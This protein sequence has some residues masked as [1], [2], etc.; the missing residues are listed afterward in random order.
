VIDF[1]HA[2][3]VS[4]YEKMEYVVTVANELRTCDLPFVVKLQQSLS[5]YGTFIVDS[6]AMR[7]NTIVQLTSET[8]P[9]LL[10]KVSSANVHLHPAA[11]ILSEF[12]PSDG[13]MAISFF[14]KPSARPVFI[15]GTWQIFNDERHFDGCFIN[16]TE[17]DRIKH[18]VQDL[19]ER[20][21]IFVNLRGYCGPIGIDVLKN[22]Y[23]GKLFIVDLNARPCAS[24]VVGLLRGHFQKRGLQWACLRE[25]VKVPF[26]R[27]EFVEV[28]KQELM[29]GKVVIVSWHEEK[30][31]GGSWGSFVVGAEDQKDLTLTVQRLQQLKRPAAPEEPQLGNGS[32]ALEEAQLDSPAAPGELQPDNGPV[33]LEEAQLESPATPG[34]LQP[35]NGPVALEEAQLDSPAALEEPKP[36]NGP[37]ALV[38]A[39]LDS[40]ATPGEA[41]LDNGP[42]T[43]KEAQ[44]DSLATPGKPQPYDGMVALKEAQLDSPATPGEPQP[45]NGTV[46]LEEAQLHNDTAALEEA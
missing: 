33:V 38:E 36:Y 26:T 11:V 9:T 37:V 4:E 27:K 46:A 21:A 16:Y 29:D 39:Q 32:V 31:D 44:L 7:S 12:I 13:S 30:K 41:Q 2:G 8:L 45:Y 5:G 19:M 17:Q 28:M 10:N 18:E 14:V 1:E 24:H 25:M 43:L 6:E 40:H 35:D 42:V 15:S 20:A 23:T 34:E 22:K 3:P